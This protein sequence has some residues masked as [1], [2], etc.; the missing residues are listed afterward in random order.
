MWKSLQIHTIDEL[1]KNLEV[2]VCP[3][4]DKENISDDALVPEKWD[5]RLFGGAWSGFLG[6]SG[7]GFLGTS[8]SGF[9]GT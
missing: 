1:E 7:S 6:T 9:L 4:M 2:S 5:N 3:K 8:G